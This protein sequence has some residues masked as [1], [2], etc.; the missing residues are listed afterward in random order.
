MITSRHKH[1]Y[2]M[3]THTHTQTQARLKLVSGSYERGIQGGGHEARQTERSMGQQ[4]WNGG[5][6]GTVDMCESTHH[7]ILICCP[8]MLCKCV[9]AS[10]V[11]AL[12]LTVMSSVYTP[13][14]GVLKS[15]VSRLLP[16]LSTPR[17]PLSGTL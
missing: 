13:S 4:M 1:T 16:P 3:D 12:T 15:N 17:N 5:W 6:A 9:Y 10:H 7:P 11:H 14:S 2:T 8:S